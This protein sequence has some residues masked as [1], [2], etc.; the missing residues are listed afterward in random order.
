MIPPRRL[1]F[2]GG[3]IKVVSIVGSLK[4]LE[5]GGLLK[6]V[7]EVSGVSAGAWLGFMFSCGLTLETIEKLVLDLDF[8]IIRNVTA[9]AFLGFPETFGLDDGTYLRKFLESI[10]RIAMKMDPH[11]TF[12]SI[13]SNRIR[14][15]CWATDLNTLNIRE[16]SSIKTPTVKIVDALYASMAIPFYFTPGKDSITGHLLSDGGIQGSLP[17][18]HLT[19]DECSDCLAIGFCKNSS[20]KEEEPQDLMAF[21]SS[22]FSSILHINNQAVI[23]KWSHKILR[24]PVDEFPSWNFEVSREDRIILIKKG[25]EATKKWILNARNSLKLILRRHSV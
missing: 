24:I 1:V 12:D 2:S 17:L 25:I 9:D 13:K 6:N 21:I 11:S 23:K 3:G 14:F 5:E 4:V 19:D 22:I 7:N 8:S 15:R 18:H 10:M 16:F 20:A